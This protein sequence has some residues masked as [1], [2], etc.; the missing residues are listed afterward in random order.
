MEN[1]PE[2]RSVGVEEVIGDLHLPDPCT[3]RGLPCGPIDG[4]YGGERP[5]ALCDRN[6]TA[7]L[8]DVIEHREALRFELGHVNNLM[9]HGFMLAYSKWSSDQSGA[10]RTLDL[11][12]VCQMEPATRET[13]RRELRMPLRS[14]DYVADRA[15]HYVGILQV[16]AM[17]RYRV[18]HDFAVSGQSAVST[19]LIDFLL[20]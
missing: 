19:L 1:L 8:P 2:A 14:G 17:S 4:S 7:A 16:D 5:P 12:A 6:R 11:L 18:F 15:Y 9:L 20:N 10:A 3:F 13:S